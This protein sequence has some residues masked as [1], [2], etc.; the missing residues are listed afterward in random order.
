MSPALGLQMNTPPHFLAHFA[1]QGGVSLLYICRCVLR[2]V[3][4]LLALGVFC[5]FSDRPL[6][7]GVVP[8]SL[9]LSIAARSEC[10]LLLRALT[11]SRHTRALW[12]NNQLLHKPAETQDFLLA[13]LMGERTQIQSLF[14]AVYSK[15]CTRQKC[16]M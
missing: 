1:A 3:C 4:R 13:G 9:S 2:S 8:H 14:H 7:Y 15:Q 10:V 12:L 5:S 11:H 16:I 6:Y